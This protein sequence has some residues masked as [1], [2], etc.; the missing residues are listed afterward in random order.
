L[1]P[2]PAPTRTEDGGWVVGVP[3]AL[4]RLHPSTGAPWVSI[5]ACALAYTAA[6]RLGFE[7]LVELDVLLYG[8]SLVLEFVALVVLR[9]REPQLARPFRIPGGLAAAIAIGIPPTGL[10][11]VALVAGRQE[12]AGALSTL[13]LGAALIAAGPA[14][15]LLSRRMRAH[16]TDAAR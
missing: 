4:A 3:A 16:A 6:L 14:V 11:A 8:L 10:L 15:F 1:K 12:R 9:V 13:S 7:R 2:E 5:V